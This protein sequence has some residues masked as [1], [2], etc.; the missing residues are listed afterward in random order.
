MKLLLLLLHTTLTTVPFFFTVYNFYPILCKRFQI[1]VTFC[2]ANSPVCVGWRW[3]MTRFRHAKKGRRKVFTFSLTLSLSPAAHLQHRRWTLRNSNFPFTT[4][5]CRWSGSKRR[6]SWT[7][8]SVTSRNIA[9]HGT[10]SSFA[11][12]IS[13]ISAIT[14]ATLRTCWARVKSICFSRASQTRRSSARRLLANIKTGMCGGHEIVL[15]CTT[16]LLR[17]SQFWVG[18]S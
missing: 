18:F 11:K 16:F 10:R 14:R 2:R 6:C 4:K 1:N 7:R 15:C 13:R 5:I 12:S 17:S 8:P 9:A 3:R